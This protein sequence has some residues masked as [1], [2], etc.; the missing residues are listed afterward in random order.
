[1]KRAPKP[2]FAHDCDDC[3]FLGT[4]E[5]RCTLSRPVSGASW[6]FTVDKVEVPGFL[7]VWDLYHCAKRPTV[8]ARY[9]DEGPSYKSGLQ[10]AKQ[11]SELA[12]AE[13]LAIEKG[14]IS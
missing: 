1:M 3:T 8:I 13:K 12:L 10:F 11:D 2:V 6:R 4:L 5:Y 14:L 7:T 9:G